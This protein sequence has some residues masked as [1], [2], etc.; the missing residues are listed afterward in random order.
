MTASSQTSRYV[1]ICAALSVLTL[2][3]Y[4]QVHTFDFVS[5]DDPNYV[6]R[7]L[8]VQAGITVG[9]VD[10]ALTAGRSAN[11]HPLTWLS[12][13]LDW[14]LFGANAGGPHTVNLIFHIAN[15]L[16][17]FLVLTRMTNALWQS[18]FVAALFA[19]HPLHVESVAWVSERKDVLSTFFWM[20]TMWAY[21]WYVR[22][23]GA[24]RYLLALLMFALGLT[25]K[26]MLVTL[27]F[28]LLLLDYWPL[29]RIGA[30]QQKT[31]G[32][33][34]QRTLY[35]LVYEKVPF[36]VLSTASSIITLVVQQRD[37][38]VISLTSFP[39]KYRIA[40]AVISYAEYA[41]KMF[42]PSRLA[43]F[44]PH[45]GENVSVLYLIM[46]VVVLL[47][48]TILVIRLAAN[49]RY[50]VTGWFWYLGTLFPVIGLVQVGVQ[51]LADRYT[52]VPLVGLF[53]M[54]AWGVPDL[55]VKLRCRRI[56]LACA[57]IAAVSAMSV[58][59]FFQLRHWKDTSTL[60][61]H[62][63]DVTEDNVVAI[64]NL[65]WFLAT[66]PEYSGQNPQRAI[67]LAMRACELNHY[68]NAGSTDTLA[69]AYAAAG[70]FDKA[71]ET[72]QRALQLCRSP[73]QESLREE[74]RK[75]L[76]LFR[77][78]KSYIEPE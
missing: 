57:A 65:A 6:Y 8:H 17:L 14:Q 7:N 37:Q 78:G 27:P 13:T 59:T 11:W 54:I 23:P 62:A 42:W 69:V 32:Q 21:L 52:Y 66:S 51:G 39:L 67:R 26:P 46:S 34:R 49:H 36:I 68:R 64:N 33:E 63:I 5:Y 44:Y 75:R 20:L 28:V 48:V 10:W 1:F 2:A 35:R 29:E 31:Q 22:K 50:L 73:G 72:D 45:P 55:L 41:K 56:I 60:L 30:K 12:H 16:L 9:S 19:L 70:D 25:A 3:I 15:T 18:A 71:I 76:A 40:N 24:A 58:C 47:A 61:Q 4:Y 38:A 53:I 77:A 74:I 43:V